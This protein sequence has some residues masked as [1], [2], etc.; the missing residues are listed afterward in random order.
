M[1]KILELTDRSVYAMTRLLAGSQ[2]HLVSISDRR[3]RFSPKRQDR[4]WSPSS[5]LVSN[6][7][8]LLLLS[9]LFQ[10]LGL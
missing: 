7:S 6:N 9:F 3:K 4:L 2:G 5:I 1:R 8:E 10:A